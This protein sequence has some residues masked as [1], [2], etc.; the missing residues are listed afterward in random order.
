LAFSTSQ[1]L[2]IIRT[3]QIPRILLR[4]FDPIAI[5]DLVARISV[6]YLGAVFEP[7]TYH[8]DRII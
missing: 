1:P 2:G 5:V 8:L 6:A 3:V 4:F 7:S